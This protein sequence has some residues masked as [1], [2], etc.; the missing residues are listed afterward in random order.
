MNCNLHAT[1]LVS[2]LQVLVDI[3]SQL[4]RDGGESPELTS[5]TTYLAFLRNATMHTIERLHALVEGNSDSLLLVLGSLAE[6]APKDVSGY[7]TCL[8]VH[9]VV[10]QLY[11][12]ERIHTYILHTYVGPLLNNN[13]I[14]CKCVFIFFPSIKQV[15]EQV[16]TLLAARLS[17]N[18][19]TDDVIHL[20]HS[21]G[22]TGSKAAVRVLLDYLKEEDL[23]V[24]LAAIPSLRMHTS[25]ERVQTAFT[26]LLGMSKNEEV[27][28]N[29]MQYNHTIPL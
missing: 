10:K 18:Q 25:S 16:V 29:C 26:Q 23:D 20:L 4:R 1:F 28:F 19:D 6:F 21:L 24:Q 17:D 11:A 3:Y 13:A 7:I 2:C 5:L 8:T 14:M 15:Q 27:G 22:N 12:A 9:V